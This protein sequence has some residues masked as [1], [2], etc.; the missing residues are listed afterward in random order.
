MRIGSHGKWYCY[1][2]LTV[3]KLKQHDQ[4]PWPQIF[5]NIVQGVISSFMH[6]KASGTLLL[7]VNLSQKYLY[8]SVRKETCPDRVIGPVVK[9]P[10]DD[11]NL[12]ISKIILQGKGGGGG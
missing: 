7:H 5:V 8:S 3:R 10:K 6:A 9:H 1:A 2:Y 4:L 11:Y 12:F